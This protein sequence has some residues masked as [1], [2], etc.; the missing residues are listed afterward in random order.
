MSFT[1]ERE[2]AQKNRKD[3]AG[4]DRMAVMPVG[5]LVVS[6]SL[7]MMVSFFIQALYNVVDSIFVAQISENALT[8][9]SLAFPMQMVMHAIAVGVGVGVSAAVPRALGSGDR[10]R[11]SRIAGTAVIINLALTAFFMILGFT[12]ARKL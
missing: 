8:A 7:P 11:A 4:G 9:V 12:S 3:A 1:E 10:R 5:R 2:L 6:M